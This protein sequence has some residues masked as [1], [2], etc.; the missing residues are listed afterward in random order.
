MEHF[1]VTNATPRL[2]RAPEKP[3]GIDATLAASTWW[4]SGATY[5]HPAGSAAA[6]FRG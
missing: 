3:I 2:G 5:V 4:F 1:S 6:V